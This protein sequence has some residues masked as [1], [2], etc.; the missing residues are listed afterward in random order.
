MMA[1]DLGK[2]LIVTITTTRYILVP[3]LRPQKTRMIDLDG[4]GFG[5][6]ASAPFDAGETVM[7]RTPTP[8][9][10]P[11]ST[12]RTQ[13]HAIAMATETDTVRTVRTKM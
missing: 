8:F 4:D 6:F 3:L 9:Q 11:D 7:I 5:E 12:N 1:M 10:M 13:T 2:T